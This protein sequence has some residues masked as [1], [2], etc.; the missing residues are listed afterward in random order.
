[1]EYFFEITGRGRA[2]RQEIEATTVEAYRTG[3]KI[4]PRI[5]HKN[6]GAS[7][8]TRCYGKS[9]HLGYYGHNKYRIIWRRQDICERDNRRL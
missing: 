1:V 6:D 9:C 2:E 5:W 3:K 7:S 8:R 4:R